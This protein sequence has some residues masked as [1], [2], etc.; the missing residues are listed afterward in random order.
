MLSLLNNKVLKEWFA[1]SSAYFPCQNSTISTMGTEP[2]LEQDL[3]DYLRAN[4]LE[5]SSPNEKTNVLIVGNQ[6]CD[7][8][9]L[10]NLL[11]KRK[12]KNLRIYS[13]EMFLAHWT[14][15]QDPFENEQVANAFAEGHFTLEFL[16]ENC[17][18]DWVSTDVS[19][20]I[21][22]NSF[23]TDSPKIGVLKEAGY[24]VGKTKGLP[25]PERQKILTKVFTSE[26]SSILSIEYIK[27]LKNN[28]PTY[29]QEWGEPKSPQRLSKIKD[30]LGDFCRKQK[31]KG[32]ID[33][34]FDYDED[35]DWIETCIR[36]GRFRLRWSKAVVV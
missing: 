13:Q 2:L 11:D 15:G 18:V 35:L 19:P 3:D 8:E 5:V 26:L 9:Q 6:G 10:K 21:F 29:L 24:T 33:A 34:A 17:W 12:G 36:T 23:S 4:G 1:N 20:N 31:S 7:E 14:T 25:S 22:G 28:Y 27:D 16:I 32:N 30:C